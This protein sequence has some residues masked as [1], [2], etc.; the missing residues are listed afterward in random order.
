MV[1]N[2]LKFN[3]DKI[4]VQQ[5]YYLLG[6]KIIKWLTTSSNYISALSTN[7][8]LSGFYF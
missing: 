3:A 8:T 6:E 4:R 5:K 1:V 7:G 2:W